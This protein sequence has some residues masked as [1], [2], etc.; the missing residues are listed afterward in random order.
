MTVVDVK[1]EHGMSDFTLRSLTLSP[2]ECVFVHEV[3]RPGA[4]TSGLTELDALAAFRWGYAFIRNIDQSEVE[5][6]V[7]D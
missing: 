6:R 2:V 1:L 5:L 4:L 3:G 7:C